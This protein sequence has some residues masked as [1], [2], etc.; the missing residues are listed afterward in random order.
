[1]NAFKKRLYFYIILN[2]ISYINSSPP[3]TPQPNY[4]TFIETPKVQI[5]DNQKS[6]LK[7]LDEAK[8]IIETTNV[9]VYFSG[10]ERIEEHF[11]KITALNLES[12]YFT[13]YSFYY[14]FSNGQTLKLNSNLCEKES[15]PEEEKELEKNKCTPKFSESA[16][17]Y[18][19]QYDFQ[20]RK[21][22]HIIINYN[23][24]I[25]K[26]PKEI[27]YRQESVSV[28]SFENTGTCTFK[29]TIPDNYTNLGLEYNL[30][31]KES[32]RVYIYNG[33]CPS[34]EISD[35]IRFAPNQG[36]WK[37]Q[38]NMYCSSSSEIS[39]NVIMTFPR[40]YRGGKNKNKNYKLTLY[41]D[42][43]LKESELIQNETLLKVIV[44][45][46][47]N[48]RI[49]VNLKTAF[50]N[51]LN[52]KFDVYTTENFYQIDENIDDVIKDKVQEIINNSSSPYKD[53]PDYYKIGKFVHSYMTYDLSY[54]GKNLTAIDIYNGKRGVCEHYTI[55]YNAM[56]NS[57]GI[58]TLSTFG[59]SLDQN[60]ISANQDTIGHAWT[61][62]LID[63][64][65]I[66]LDSTWGLFEGIPAGHIFK[67]FKKERYS[68]SKGEIELT[69]NI[70]L[71]D[72]LDD[73]EDDE[74]TI[75]SIID[76][77]QNNESTIPNSNIKTQIKSTIP[78]IIKSYQ[79]NESTIPSS[80]I[81]IQLKSSII[82]S[83]QNKESS[84][85]ISNIKTQIKSTI[86]SI[87]DSHQ[88]IES[89]I[90]KSNIKTQIKS[91]IQSIIDSHQ[92]IESTILKSNI[93]TQIKSTI[94]SIINN[95]QNKESTIQKLIIKTQIKSTITSIINS[96]QNNES[97]IPISNIKTQIKS[98][99]PSI[100]NSYQNN[101][102]IIL[103]S[104]IK[105]Q[106]K[107]NIPSI[108]NSYQEN[109]STNPN[110]NIKTQIK[111]NI[112]SIIDSHQNNLFLIELPEFTIQSKF[113]QEVFRE[114]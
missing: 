32:D 65:W 96:Y 108:V 9:N 54:L 27:L 61:L 98:T 58:K 23:I 77:Y 63:N 83:Y 28:S 101:E 70:N 69:T 17:R 10:N 64:K 25:I 94:P 22:E 52:E 24:S 34:E 78:S 55:L 88:N 8:M 97:T 89:T 105:T 92:N 35:V 80:N 26:E 107:S 95:Y 1:M 71:V 91:T 13:G 4:Q 56:L 99:I 11:I 109:E 60:Q 40:Y 66:E 50:S 2:I 46:K 19:F 30:L 93:K 62:A 18:N 113:H 45:G 42:T 36:F 81:K 85:S 51:K 31:K 67:G 68:I 90:P 106:I 47:N 39:G 44:P 43:K 103:N 14:I 112:P 75:P 33:E 7:N 15:V 110:S 5:D 102:S 104:N 6:F 49:G 29:F 114:A 3:P 59:W 72:N 111:S 100:I 79:N 37:A 41:D 74:H 16:Q 12:S 84:I 73:E 86:P 20:L 57:I 87:I 76:N 21:N 48:K 53:Y 82:D 38:V